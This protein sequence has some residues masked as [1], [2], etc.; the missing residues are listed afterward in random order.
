MAYTST[1]INDLMDDVKTTVETVAVLADATFYPVPAQ[2][3]GDGVWAYIEYGPATIEQASDEV[4]VHQ[5][6]IN[7]MVPLKGNYDLDAT[8]G[9]AQTLCLQTAFAIHR[10]F[11]TNVMVAGEAAVATPGTISKP[12]FAQFG[13]VRNIGC[14]LTMQIVTSE[15]V[16]AL[17]ST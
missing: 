15:D 1:L 9:G 4:I 12:F 2:S 5:F 16:S 13:E 8:S 10:A 14:T 11:Y 3:Q 17:V 6:E 7:V